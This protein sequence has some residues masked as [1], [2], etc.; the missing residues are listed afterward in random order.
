MDDQN[1]IHVVFGESTIGALRQGLRQSGV[2]DQILALPD[3]LSYGPVT[4]D[5]FAARRAWIMENFSSIK[6]DEHAFASAE[7]VADFWDR[8]RSLKGET[9]VWFTRRSSSEYC[10]F[11][12]CLYRA[13]DPGRLLF[14]DLTEERRRGVNYKGQPYDAPVYRTAFLN[15][16]QLMAFYG[17]W[18]PMPPNAGKAFR[19]EWEVLRSENSALRVLENGALKSAPIDYFDEIIMS[20]VTDQWRKGARVVGGSMGKNWG[21]EW[22]NDIGDIAI[23]AR[24]N[25]LIDQGRV[26][27]QGDRREMRRMEVRRAK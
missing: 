8:F 9:V 16:E 15:P 5:D 13:P 19:D 26:E 22:I 21:D 27:F 4:G 12:E 18:K 3:D 6:N 2:H 14:N 17:R 23:F 10:G 7:E 11:L 1:R 24:L 20:E 25:A